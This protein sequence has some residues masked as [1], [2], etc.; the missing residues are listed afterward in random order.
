MHVTQYRR[1]E[2]GERNIPLEIAVS[3]AKLYHVS[4][5]YLAGLTDVEQPDLSETDLSSE[6]QIMLTNYRKLNCKN[7]VRADERIATL[8]DEQK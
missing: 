2:T 7:K 4:L 6:E 5:D 8:L 1:Y 3:L